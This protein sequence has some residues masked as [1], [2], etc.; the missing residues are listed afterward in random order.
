ME[1]LQIYFRMLKRG[2]WLIA[3]AA[4]A[5]LN[6]ALISS[7][8]ATPMFKTTAS[9][10]VSP[11]PSLLAGQDKEVIN[12][13][14]ALDKRSIVS[15]YAEVL[16]SDTVFDTA[17]SEL[18]LDAETLNGYAVTAVVLPD[19]SVLELTVEGPDPQRIA[20]LANQIG[21]LS[22]EYIEELYLIYDINLLDRATP[23]TAPF[24]PQPIRDSAVAF[25]LGAGFGAML[26]ILRELLS[27]PFD[28]WRRRFNKDKSS[29]A[30]K[31]RVVQNRLNALIAADAADPTTFG[32]LQFGSQEGL[33]ALSPTQKQRLL[34]QITAVLRSELRGKDTIGRWRENQFA[35]LLPGLDESAGVE[36]V[37]KLA[38]KLRLPLQ[39][40]GVGEPLNLVVAGGVAVASGNQTGTETIEQAKTALNQ[41]Q[42][43]KTAVLLFKSNMNSANDSPE[44][45]LHPNLSANPTG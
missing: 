1:Q 45:T 34:R 3:L 15:T 18:G 8:L 31:R 17:V 37:E 16:K 2:W 7:F 9:F 22:I 33:D 19:A 21:E 38:Q 36:V 20:L 35:L 42:R 5:G 44:D 14:E 40:D 13:I 24:S 28:M 4:L 32:L 10:I 39:V 11:G 41:A 43:G 6:T 12:S 29:L 25:I 30:Q 23:P 27:A 26:A